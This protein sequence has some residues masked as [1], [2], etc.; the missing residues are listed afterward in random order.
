M[1]LKSFQDVCN[2]HVGQ[3]F[4][5]LPQHPDQQ[6]TPWSTNDKYAATII[7]FGPELFFVWFFGHYQE[8]LQINSL[9]LSCSLTLGMFLM[10][11]L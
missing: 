5:F 11:K 6:T 1:D 9:R 8:L 2:V 3:K 4:C 7:S 10:N